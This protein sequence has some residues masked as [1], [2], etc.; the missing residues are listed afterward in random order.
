MSLIGIFHIVLLL[1]A[2]IG[3]IFITLKSFSS[4]IPY[5]LLTISNVIY[6]I[7]L[8]LGILWAKIE[9]GFYLNIDIKTILS[10]I[11]FILFLLENIIKINKYYLPLIGTVVLI[12]NYILPLFIYTIHTPY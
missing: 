3:Y 5:K 1:I 4:R 9:W 6:F 7:G 11:L 10:I 8:I 12:L 2:Y